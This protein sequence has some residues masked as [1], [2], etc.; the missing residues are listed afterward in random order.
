MS[1]EE[2]RFVINRLVL[3]P[4]RILRFLSVSVSKETWAWVHP[5]RLIDDM[6]EKRR[7]KE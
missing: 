5:R 4:E 6:R 1:V 3:I 7:E 2:K